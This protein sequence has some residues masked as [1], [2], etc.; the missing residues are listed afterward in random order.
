MPGQYR[1]RQTVT[2]PNE[3]ENASDWVKEGELIP[4][5]D[6]NGLMVAKMEVK[7]VTRDKIKG[8]V[9]TSY[10]HKRRK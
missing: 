1:L 8:R 4:L 2:I 3:I 10:G 5:T 9:V 7:H 6:E